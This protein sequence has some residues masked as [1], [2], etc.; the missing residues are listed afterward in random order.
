MLLLI[1]FTA[2]FGACDSRESKEITCDEIIKVYEDAGYYVF[3]GQHCGEEGYQYRCYICVKTS[4]NDPSDQAYFTT[5]WTEE[6]AEEA[7]EIDKYHIAKWIFAL[8]FGEYRWLKTGTYGAI[9]YSYYNSEM[10][11][12][13]KSLTKK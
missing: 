10:I 5:Y 3:H 6:E 1:A 12:P 7:A 11:K 13:F 8:P 9:E 2:S 4:E